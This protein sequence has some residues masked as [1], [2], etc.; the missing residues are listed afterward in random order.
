MSALYIGPSDPD[1]LL[2]ALVAPIQDPVERERMAAELRA[3]REY[4][5]SDA[6]RIPARDLRHVDLH[7]GMGGGA[8]PSYARAHGWPER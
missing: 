7:G 2:A 8:W 4:R 1:V 5:Q 6:G 3:A